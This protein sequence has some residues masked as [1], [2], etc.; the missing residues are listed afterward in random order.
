MHL[1]TETGTTSRD[2]DKME[3]PEDIQG[4]VTVGSI[5][6]LNPKLQDPRHDDLAIGDARGSPEETLLHS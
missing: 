4:T 5:P 2:S 1:K 6:N 3:E